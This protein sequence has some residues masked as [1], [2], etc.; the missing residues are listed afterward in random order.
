MIKRSLI[1][2]LVTLITLCMFFLFTEKVI[3]IV[4]LMECMYYIMAIVYV[5]IV[6][7]FIQVTL[8]KGLY[9]AEKNSEI[10][11]LIQVK[12]KSKWLSVRCGFKINVV[13]N[14]TGEV[15]KEIINHTV[16]R[17]VKETFSESFLS[18]DCGEIS[19]YLV[20]YYVY[21]W[22]GCLYLKKKTND[23]KKIEIL[24]ETH[25][26]MTEIQ[27][28]TREFI[29]DSEVYSDSEKGDDLSE[30]YQVREYVEGDPIHDI[31]WKLSAKTDN[32]LIKEHGKPLGC[33]VLIWIDLFRNN[34][35]K[36]L[37]G[38][39]HG[40]KNLPV[41]AIEMAAS[42]SLSLIE[43][44]CVHMVAWYEEKNDRI[45]RKRVENEENIYELLNRLLYLESYHDRKRADMQFDERFDR[46]DFSSMVEIKSDGRLIV[47]GNEI[48]VKKKGDKVCYEETYI[49][50]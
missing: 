26:L 25:L 1:Y 4:L 5:R 32:L 41:N 11:I 44:K 23:V 17:G 43:Q 9:S 20:E 29:A 3:G 15:K 49:I 12:N 7:R 46:N 31:H 13:N 28:T 10:P 14:F 38:K 30:I 27:R 19:V 39:K 37:R 22:I 45:I 42:V 35:V 2:G 8:D 40:R 24:P 18:T 48:E 36:H 33:V 47:N 21:D 34:T 16:T 6:S 50:V